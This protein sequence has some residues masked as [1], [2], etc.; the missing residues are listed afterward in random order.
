MPTKQ[1]DKESHAKSIRIRF[2]GQ[3]LWGRLGE[4]LRQALLRQQVSPHN[5]SAYLSCQGIGSCG[6][7][8]VEIIR[9]DAGPVTFMERWRLN[10]PPHTAGVKPMRL[11]CQIKLKE[12]LEI[13]KSS[14]FWGPLQRS[15]VGKK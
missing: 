11:A 3:E 14:G 12:P 1:Q 5:Q 9:G 15:G 6:T 7:C 8:A 13:R 4:N 10:F 2:A